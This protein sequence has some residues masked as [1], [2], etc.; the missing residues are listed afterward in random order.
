MD[1]EKSSA[2]RP[3]SD[4]Y[5]ALLY[6]PTFAREQLAIINALKQEFCAIPIAVSDPRVARVKLEWWHSEIER[7]VIGAPRH[8]LT[9]TYFRSFGCDEAI[10]NALNVLIYGLDEELGGRNLS[11]EDQRISWFDTTF[12]PLYAAQASI[13]MPTGAIA[14]GPWQNLGRWIEIGYSLLSLRPLAARNLV[15]IPQE[16]IDAT[17]CTFPNF[18]SGRSGAEMAELID[19]ECGITINHIADII[20]QSPTKTRRTLRPLFTSACIVQRT[21]IE[22]RDDGCRI[23]QHQLE[24]TPLRKLWLAWRMRFL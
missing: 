23:W 17:G 6:A 9:Q 1:L 7:L 15:R 24:L 13:L 4:I 14:A 16:S 20:A 11:T 22:L 18:K 8:Q 10:G 2:P 5:Y 12:G 21:L 3:G 19:T